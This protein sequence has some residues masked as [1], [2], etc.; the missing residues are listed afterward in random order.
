MV[1]HL[2][3]PIRQPWHEVLSILADGLGLQLTDSLPFKEW[4]QELQTLSS[5]S[6]QALELSEFFEE[7]F[8]HMACGDVIMDTYQSRHVSL[9]LRQMGPVN[10]EDVSK[11]I[12]YWKKTGIL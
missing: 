4:I 12:R 8:E 11:Y 6:S 3:N 7:D 1:Y 10:G 5:A 2:E 9:S